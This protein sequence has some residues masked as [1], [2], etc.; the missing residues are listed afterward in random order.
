MTTEEPT[1]EPQG[2]PASQPNVTIPPGQEDKEA[3]G[4]KDDDDAVDAGDE[5]P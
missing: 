3:F 5:T 1:Q 2:Q 4:D